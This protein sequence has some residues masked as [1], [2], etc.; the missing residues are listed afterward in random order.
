MKEDLEEA[1]RTSRATI[2]EW[3]DELARHMTRCV[4]CERWGRYGSGKAKACA[5]G[6]RLRTRAGNA[7]YNEFAA[8]A[9]QRFMSEDLDVRS[10]R[11]KPRACRVCSCTEASPCLL[12][13]GEA[14]HWIEKDLCS[15]SQCVRAPN[16]RDRRRRT[17]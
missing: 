13:S 8:M 10:K 3:V 15:A 6:S 2:S 11:P 14:C 16:G 7:L 5:E 9:Y 4:K 1:T 17:S 12:R